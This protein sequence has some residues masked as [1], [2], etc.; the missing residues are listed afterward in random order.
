MIDPWA[1]SPDKGS[2]SSSAAACSRYLGDADKSSEIAT[3]SSPRFR[4]SQ[5]SEGAKQKKVGMVALRELTVV[6]GD[7]PLGA[8]RII[9]N[10]A[11]FISLVVAA[12]T[13]AQWPLVDES[14]R[15]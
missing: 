7:V 6:R 1:P 3:R 11:W 4:A 8:W 5:R 2:G 9:G 13:P 14:G 15:S 10:E 12:H